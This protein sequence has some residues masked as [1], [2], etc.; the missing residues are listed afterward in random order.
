MDRMICSVAFLNKA[1]VSLLGDEL[2][3]LGSRI[4]FFVG[5]R[6]D[7]TSRQGIQ[8]LMDAGVNVHYVDTGARH[9]IFHP[10]LYCAF[11]SNQAR[12]VIG[13]ANL[14]PGG[15]NNNIEAS[16]ALDLD[17]TNTADRALSD[18][19][20]EG[21]DNLTS[22]YPDHVVH[23]QSA[24]QLDRLQEEGRLLDEA[25][26]SPPRS[27]GRG[28]AGDTDRLPRI[29]LQVRPIR[30]PV[31]RL[32]PRSSRTFTP[33]GDQRGLL[34]PSTSPTTETGTELVWRSK[35]LTER[36]LTIPSR[37]GTHPT[38]SINL[39]KGLLEAEIDHRHYFREEVF[40]AL[41]WQPRTATVDEASAEFELIVKGVN[42]GTHQLWIRHTNSTDSRAYEQR[43]AMTRLSWGTARDFIQRRELIGRTLSLYRDAARPGRFL[44]EID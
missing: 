31:A 39:D 21:F 12:I 4:D 29:P 32:R 44:I 41:D 13:S 6:N 14:T 2:T 8:A 26:A 15:L 17:L 11:S 38:G 9:V 40:S 34:Q 36:D 19:V 23:L 3:A 20:R 24:A 18:S 5:I 42:H 10:K 7:I 33:S 27:Q 35:S 22:E 30:S 43:N 25:A 16:A 37:A 1:G 28:A